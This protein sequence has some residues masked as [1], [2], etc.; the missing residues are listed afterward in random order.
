MHN[1]SNYQFPN[2]SLIDISKKDVI[3]NLI[4][5][6]PCYSDFNLLSLLTWN[7]EN[8]NSFSILNNNLVICIKDYLSDGY[9]Y[10]ILGKNDIDISL[11]AL[12]EKHEKLCFVP[13]M[14]IQNCHN[15][16]PYNFEEDLDSYDYIINTQYMSELQGKKYKSLRKAVNTFTQQIKDFTIKTLDLTSKSDVDNIIKLTEDWCNNKNFDEKKR[17]EDVNSIKKFIDLSKYFNTLSLGLYTNGRLI[18]FTLNEIIDDLWAM[19]HF[20]KADNNYEKCSYFLEHISSKILLERGIIYINIQQ[21]AGILGLR[22]YKKS[23]APEYYFK[24]F[25]I[26]KL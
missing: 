15:K 16:S 3:S 10:S 14:V 25:T 19:G 4:S 11:N 8:N 20:G 17:L 2:F 1:I 24:K 23:L 12:L 22:E 26:T 5:D 18:A 6:L 21:D 9:I 7:A 13:E